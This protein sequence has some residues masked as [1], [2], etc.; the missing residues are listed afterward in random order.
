MMKAVTRKGA[1][2]RKGAVTRTRI[3]GR[4]REP[5][6][7]ERKLEE[8]AAVLN[9]QTFIDLYIVTITYPTRHYKPCCTPIDRCH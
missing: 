9:K 7:N 1:A 5:Y 2:V 4:Q 6:D 3:T 8:N